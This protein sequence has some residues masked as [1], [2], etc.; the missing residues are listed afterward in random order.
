MKKRTKNSILPAPAEPFKLSPKELW[1]ESQS[2]RIAQ[3]I[4]ARMKDGLPYPI[5]GL[6][7][8]FVSTTDGK[9][10]MILDVKDKPSFFESVKKNK[11]ILEGWRCGLTAFED[12][13]KWELLPPTTQILIARSKKGH[14]CL[15]WMKTHEPER[16]K[17]CMAGRDTGLSPGQ[18][19]KELNRTLER[20]LKDHCKCILRNTRAPFTR[21]TNS[22][23]LLTVVGLKEPD[24]HRACDELIENILSGRKPFH[25]SPRAQYVIPV[26][27]R[28]IEN[29]FKTWLPK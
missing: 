22:I 1:E 25:T 16:W 17:F 21:V 3:F 14:A 6:T 12:L 24:A 28:M 13:P 9:I 26:T 15:E 10:R 19:S 23:S 4:R 29:R 11:M 5:P 27:Q 20:W 7:L 2:K 18:L 8:N